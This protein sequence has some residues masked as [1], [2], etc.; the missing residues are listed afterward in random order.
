MVNAKTRRSLGMLL[1]LLTLCT[2]LGGSALAATKGKKSATLTAGKKKHVVSLGSVEAGEEKGSYVV[3]LKLKENGTDA[4]N[5][6]KG[7]LTNPFGVVIV[8]GKKQIPFEEMG[9]LM[10]S[11]KDAEGNYKFAFDLQYAFESDKAPS[12]VIVYPE[13]KEPKNGV[14]FDAK[15]MEVVKAASASKKK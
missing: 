4:L 8:V 1:A 6:E 3:V 14:T 13:D 9:F 12:Q 7:E 5:N 2:L 10:G 15:T 11:K